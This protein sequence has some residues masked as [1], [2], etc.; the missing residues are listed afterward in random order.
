VFQVLGGVDGGENHFA[1]FL[2]GG[3]VDKANSNRIR[4]RRNGQRSGDK[5]EKAFARVIRRG[6]AEN[7]PERLDEQFRCDV[8]SVG[9]AGSE[10]DDAINAGSGHCH[11]VAAE[12]SRRRRGREGSGRS[13]LNELGEQA[14]ECG[15]GRRVHVFAVVG[16]DKDGF[17]VCLPE[18]VLGRS[19]CAI[20]TGGTFETGLLCELGRR[21]RFD[22]NGIALVLD[23]VLGLGEVDVAGLAANLFDAA[24][25]G[26]D[27]HDD[28]LLV[29]IN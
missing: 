13:D 1:N 23:A 3:R 4:T 7:V 12:N 19:E 25:E 2:T 21:L 17:G 20:S 14:D 26:H 8:C 28:W 5:G 24:I 18:S 9:F 6:L 15:I 22:A 10:G 11:A 27:C 16:V 29:K